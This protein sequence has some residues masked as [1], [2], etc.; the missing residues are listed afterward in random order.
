MHV[1]WGTHR[2]PMLLATCAVTFLG[3]GC[4]NGVVTRD[5]GRLAEAYVLFSPLLS[6]TT[7]LVDRDG[8]VVHEWQS[9]FAPGA[10]VHFLDDGSLLR[11]AR[12]PNVPRYRGGGLGGRLQEF[13]WDGRLTWDW[14]IASGERLQHHDVAPL[15]GG[16]VL[17]LAWEAK[18]REEALRAGRVPR[19]VGS[20]GLWPECVFEVRPVRPRG[21]VIVWEWHLWD[22]LVQE[23]HTGLENYGRIAD[24]PGRIDIN[25]DS[26]PQSWTT[27]VLDRLK[28]LGYI[29]TDTTASDLDPDFVHA[30]A[31]A[32]NP[33]LDQIALTVNHYHEVWVIDHST[34]TAEAATGAGGRRNR[35]GDLLY[36]W[37]NPAAYARGLAA[38]QRLF[39]PHDGRWIPDGYPGAGHLL[40]FNNGLGSRRRASSVIE[41]DPPLDDGRYRIGPRAPF[42]PVSPAWTYPPPSAKPFYADFI[43]GAHRLPNGNTF[44]TA[45]PE[46]RFFEV[47]AAG[48]TVWEY[49]NPYSGTAPNP[50]GDPPRSVFRATLIPGNHPGLANRGLARRR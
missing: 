11:C 34:T 13:A 32:Y 12:Q 18:T 14:I 29:G 48:D 50:A 43:S 19:R 4:T 2:R 6:T 40:V 39:G 44:I 37:G 23:V 10:S 26:A 7:Y 35:G 16:N 15:P 38:D 17:V 5:A 25:G 22:H 21:G 36:R 45:G 42:E 47:T 49:E 28:S 9:D 3:C 1:F 31:I 27:A 24:H 33:R 20:A 8:R 41:I 46:G 30:N